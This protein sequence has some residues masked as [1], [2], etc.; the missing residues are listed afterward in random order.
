[1]FHC[2]VCGKQLGALNLFRAHLKRHRDSGNLK[3]P[4]LCLQDSCKSSFST[5]YNRFRHLATF[6]GSEKQEQV[7][8]PTNGND[9]NV[10]EVNWRD[11]GDAEVAVPKPDSDTDFMQN[12]QTEGV[13]LVTSLRA[14]SSIP[15]GIISDV[16]SSF[17]HMADFLTSLIHQEAINSMHCVGISP[18]LAGQVAQNLESKLEL[19]RKPLDFLATQYKCDT[20]F[21]NHPLAVMPEAVPFGPQLE[22]HD[23]SSSFVYDT[24]QYVSVHKTLNCILQMLPMLRHC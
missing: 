8:L 11:D 7:G 12:L 18:S 4:V 23:G 6:H 19:Y 17:N 2:Y 22:S 20:Y 1:M 3:S 10:E 16:V 24:F 14:N 5:L 21:A 13:S 15:Y 9:D